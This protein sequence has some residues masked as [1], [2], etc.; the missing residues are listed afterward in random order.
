MQRPTGLRCAEV[1]RGTPGDARCAKPGADLVV[2][3]HT[4]APLLRV[5]KTQTLV[6]HRR[7]EC[8][9]TI[10]AKGFHAPE[11]LRNGGGEA[12]GDLLSRAGGP[13][14]PQR[15]AGGRTLQRRA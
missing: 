13:A 3:Y 14:E 9:G 8:S 7:Q 11:P 6:E 1:A 2:Q 15:C 4:P 12:S 5:S 10:H